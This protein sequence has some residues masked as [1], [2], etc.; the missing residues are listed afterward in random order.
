MTGKEKCR[1]LKELRREI[2]NKNGVRLRPVPEC[3]Y[4]G[5]CPGFCPM[6]D[7]ELKEL[8]EALSA[9]EG[10]GKNIDFSGTKLEQALAQIS[11]RNLETEQLSPDISDRSSLDE[12]LKAL[13]T[14]I[15]AK[16]AK[17]SKP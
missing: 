7:A 1:Q 13:E 4:E 17:L 16:L 10:A 2:A 8:D 6:C 9:L 5:E 14:K 3:T 11:S 12:L 15:D